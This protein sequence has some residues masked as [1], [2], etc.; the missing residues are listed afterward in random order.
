MLAHVFI[1]YTKVVFAIMIN[2]TSFIYEIIR[3]VLLVLIEFGNELA[4][5]DD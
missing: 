1:I 5:D 4:G 3:S 2:Q